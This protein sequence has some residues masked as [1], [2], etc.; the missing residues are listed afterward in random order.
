MAD[1]G[2]CSMTKDEIMNIIEAIDMAEEAY[3]TRQSTVY[4]VMRKCEYG[5]NEKEAGSIL[6]FTNKEKA[7]LYV[8]KLNDG[9]K[10]LMSLQLSIKDYQKLG[11]YNKRD[12][13]AFYEK[14]SEVLFGLLNTD[15][16]LFLR[17]AITWS[18]LP[19][20]KTIETDT[21]FYIEEVNVST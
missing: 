3:N 15:E 14:Q 13:S 21:E 16:F 20:L 4:V 18:W 1:R 12:Y 6:V 10:R 5:D 9:L 2:A 7:H 17:D 19:P 8:D 11:Q